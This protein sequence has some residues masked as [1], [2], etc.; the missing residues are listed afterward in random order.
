MFRINKQVAKG[1]QGMTQFGRALA[2]LNIEILC[3]S[4][5]QAK[6]RVERANR[7]LQ[8]RL[9]K[10]CEWMAYP[11]WMPE[12]TS[13]LDLWSVSTNDSPCVQRSRGICIDG[14][15]AD[16]L[17]LAEDTVGK[18]KSGHLTSSGLFAKR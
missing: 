11:T 15:V 2:E 13:C 6:G 14:G 18:Q 7:T 10:S 3:A 4:A 12:I 8:D 9:V 1:G 17:I 16:R 5:S